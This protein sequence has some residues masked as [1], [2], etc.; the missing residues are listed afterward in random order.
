MLAPG[1][2]G[3][4]VWGPRAP[5]PEMSVTQATI[6]S[7]ARGRADTGTVRRAVGLI[8]G[9]SAAAVAGLLWILYRNTGTEGDPSSIAPWISAGL[10]TGTSIFLIVGYRAVRA[11][12]VMA[13]RRAMTVALVFSTLFLANYIAYH[14]VSGDTPFAGDGAA[15]AFYLGLLAS[16]VLMSVVALPLVLTTVWAAV[17]RRLDLHR[18]LVRFTFPVWLY[19]SVTGVLVAV[20][21]K[22]AGS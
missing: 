18:R 21:L 11:G 14:Y 2:S 7:E 17:S 3:T 19:V 20:T 15:K 16:H 10:N 4:R 1:A 9:L 5:P 22:A 12:R 13:H 8:M 6:P